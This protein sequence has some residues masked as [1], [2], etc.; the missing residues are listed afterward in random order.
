MSKILKTTSLTRKAKDGTYKVTE[1]VEVNTRIKHFR[2]SGDYIDWS[3]ETEVV[4]LTDKRAV[5][6][7]II[8]DRDGSII[9]TG[10][11]CEK[12]EDGFIN[13]TSYVENC[14]TSAWGRALGN[15]GIGIDKSIAS[16]EEVENAKELQKIQKK[17]EEDN[18]FKFE[19]CS[20]AMKFG[21]LDKAI[22]EDIETMHKIYDAAVKA[23]PANI[24]KFVFDFF[25]KYGDSFHKT[26]GQEE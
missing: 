17:A 2:E 23:Q 12:T 13:K 14:E 18:R 10:L 1:Y 26:E 3:M 8:K 21:N 24:G 7:A 22:P 15:L 11:A 25:N 4:E 6:K 9:A 19:V 20:Q 5:L 16:K